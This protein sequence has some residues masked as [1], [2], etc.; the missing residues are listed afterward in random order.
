MKGSKHIKA[1]LILGLIFVIL[2]S[3]LPVAYTV[4]YHNLTD[5]PTAID[6]SIDLKKLSP[7][8]TIVLDGRWDF[9]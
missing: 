7:T 9:F 2:F 4:F 6:G 1:N 5:A 3:H 8:R